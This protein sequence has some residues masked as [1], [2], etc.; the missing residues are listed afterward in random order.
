MLLILEDE[1]LLFRRVT[2][3]IEEIQLLEVL[4]LVSEID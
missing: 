1:Q 2:L 4:L 3:Q